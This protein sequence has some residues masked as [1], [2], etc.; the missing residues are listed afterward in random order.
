MYIYRVVYGAELQGIVSKVT[1]IL[2]EDK[3]SS[4]LVRDN[5]YRHSVHRYEMM[6]VSPDNTV[7]PGKIVCA[8][9]CLEEDIEKCKS[10]LKEEVSRKLQRSKEDLFSLEKI[11]SG[12]DPS[13]KKSM[14]SY[15]K[16]NFENGNIDHAIRCSIG[17]DD[18]MKFYIRP[19]YT[20]GD[21]LDYSVDGN[22]LIQLIGRV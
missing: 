14:E 19:A 22:I 2:V 20:N 17:S 18:H 9:Y 11:L 21:T 5:F 12:E 16:E 1:P 10:M 6:K 4:Y 3:L 15:L 7:T 8:S 13:K